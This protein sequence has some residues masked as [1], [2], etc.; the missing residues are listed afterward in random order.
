M[1]T[2]TQLPEI[3]RD[4]F[5]QR[6]R[7]CADGC[8]EWTGSRNRPG[9]YG[10]LA[11]Q[12]RWYAAHRVSWQVHFG[13]IPDGLFVCHHCDNPGCVRPDH[14][15]LGSPGENVAD[16]VRKGRMG[17]ELWLAQHLDRD[18]LAIMLA[19]ARDGVTA[20]QIA[21]QYSISPTAVRHILSGRWLRDYRPTEDEIGR[22]SIR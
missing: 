22:Y 8:W 10:K 3:V 18:D 13:D 14:L 12:R 16:A 20:E 4:R 11:V 15:F 17:G 21:P 7:Q 6:V 19:L 2:V 5:W 9:G 1:E